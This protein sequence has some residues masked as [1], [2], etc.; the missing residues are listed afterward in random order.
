M[1]IYL[2][3]NSCSLAFLG[4]HV[5]VYS[6]FFFPGHFLF[7]Y[8]KL[9]ITLTIFAGPMLII[10]SSNSIM[11]DNN[12]TVVTEDGSLAS[13]WSDGSLLAQIEHMI[14][15]TSAGAEILTQC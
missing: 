3:K 9:V 14:L 15:I 8:I 10:G 7:S 13:W 5:S 1:K 2:Y 11:W 6:G 4:G 12:W